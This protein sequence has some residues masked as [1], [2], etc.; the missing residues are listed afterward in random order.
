MALSSYLG[1]YDQS[2]VLKDLEMLGDSLTGN[3]RIRREASYRTAL[4][5]AEFGQQRQAGSIT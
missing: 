5:V 3:L 1:A 2:R 4:A